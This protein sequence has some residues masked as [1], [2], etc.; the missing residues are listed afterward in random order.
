MAAAKKAAAKAPAKKAAV[1]KNPLDELL[2]AIEE[3]RKAGYT[4]K[5]FASNG[6]GND[7]RF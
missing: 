3:A 1:K 2:K 6:D 5:G 4:V 7:V